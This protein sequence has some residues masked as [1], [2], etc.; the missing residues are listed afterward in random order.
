M[1][2][3]D[4]F[5]IFNSALNGIRVVFLC[6]TVF[7]LPPDW[8]RAQEEAPES[9]LFSCISKSIVGGPQTLDSLIA[10][11]EGELVT[12][13]LLEDT[14]GEGYEGLLQRIAS[15]QG[16]VR[17]AERY[18]G[19]RFRSLQWDSIAL[20]RCSGTLDLSGN[21]PQEAT[22]VRFETLR[23]ALLHENRDPAAEALAYLD[24][25]SAKELAFPYYRLFTYELLDR[26][27]FIT[28]SPDLGYTT[29]P[30]M[31]LNTRGANVFRVYL[32][33]R[34]QL[35]VS[36]QLVS[37][38]QMLKLVTAHARTFEQSALYIVEME[39]DVKY[40]QF[41]AIKDQIAL[42]INQLRDYYSRIILGKTL[43]ELTESEQA[44]VFGKYPIRIALP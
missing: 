9:A 38:E 31:D 42:A 29:G 25:L 10:R 19:P 20:A 41:I 18:F 5:C 14:D 32:N 30:S 16:I 3:K 35:I 36:D 37:E 44:A 8:A 43:T 23:E 7:C 39:P 40:N 26:Q 21:D 17:P 28:S 34:N 12:E 13:G 2:G 6:L 1:K 15:G 33:E 22:L 4:T 27:A 24:L 11:F